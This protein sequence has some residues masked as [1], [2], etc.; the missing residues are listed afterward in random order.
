MKK[1]DIVIFDL[2]QTLLDKDQSLLNFANYQY[3]H[4]S[5]I[6]FIPDKQ[7]FI[8]KFSELN[9][10]IMPKEEV[11]E[12]LV[13]IFNIEKSLYAELLDDLNN[14][15]HVYSVG[16]PG[17]HEMLETLKERGYKLGIITNGRDF[18]Q[19]NKISALG[20]TDYFSEVVTSGA[21]N[22][23]KPDHAI[24]QIALKNLKS[25]SECSVFIGDSLK[26]DVIPAKELGMFTILK[27]K[28]YSITEP[29]SICDNLTEI[30]NIINRIS[31]L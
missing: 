31:G 22:I 8:E 1:V 28:D 25:S 18:Y 17:L 5:L 26:A 6:R 14:N 20:I 12:K 29:D 23:K 7:D 11:Y 15:F 19:R 24:F 27:S 2:D 16:F 9:N 30:P 4:F 21:V 13:D 10:I 3:E